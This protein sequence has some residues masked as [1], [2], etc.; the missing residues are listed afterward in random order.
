MKELMNELSQCLVS[1]RGREEHLKVL[2]VSRFLPK[3]H[4]PLPLILLHPP[5]ILT[6]SYR[7]GD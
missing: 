1:L 5:K 3:L 7:A 6:H 2:V 4:N